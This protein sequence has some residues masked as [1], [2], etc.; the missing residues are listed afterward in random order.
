MDKA[1]AIEQIR[2]WIKQGVI[3]EADLSRAALAPAVE[4]GGL[5]RHRFTIAE[6]LYALGGVLVLSGIG[7]L[8]A[9]Q[10]ENLPMIARILVTFGSAVAAYGVGVALLP[11]AALGKL[12]Q[13]FA[14]LSGVLMQIGVATIFYEMNLNIGALDT[15]VLLASICLLIFGISSAVL[16]RTVFHIFT[17]LF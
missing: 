10:W 6:V 15:Q 1:T 4:R 9:Q 5:I 7:V 3:T 17:L 14:A 2:S 12:G 13:V 8:I 16:R 11:H